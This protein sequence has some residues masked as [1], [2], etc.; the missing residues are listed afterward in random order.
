M[1]EKEAIKFT[2]LQFIGII[3]VFMLFLRL[4]T[5]FANKI[6][7]RTINVFWILLVTYLIWKFV[8]TGEF[9]LHSKLYYLNK[10]PDIVISI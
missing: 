2:T 8:V 10:S 7:P 3:I 9:P 4:Q 6:P 1:V 5:V